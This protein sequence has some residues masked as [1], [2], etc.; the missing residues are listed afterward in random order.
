MVHDWV[1]CGGWITRYIVKAIPTS[2]C[3]DLRRAAARKTQSGSGSAVTYLGDLARGRDNHLNLMRMAAAMAVLV[4]HAYP[5]ALGPETVEPLKDVLGESLGTVAVFVFFA[6]SGFLITQSFERASGPA[7]WGVARVLRL[8]PGLLVVV[9]LTVLV[10]GPLVTRDGLAEYMQDPATGRYVVR[11]L[12]LVALQYDLPG[13]FD[14][15]P[16]PEVINGS[17]WTLRHEV[18]C[19]LAVLAAG[20]AGLLRPGLRMV[21]LLA[22]YALFYTA[23]RLLETESWMPELLVQ[24]RRLSLPFAIGVACY[25]WRDWLPLRWEFGAAVALAAGILSHTPLRSEALAVAIAYWVFL[26]GYLPKGRLLAYNR[27]GDYSYGVYIYAFPMQ[28]L[29]M[30]LFGPITPLANMALAVPATLLLAMLSWHFVE[31]PALAS[32]RRVMAA[33]ARRK[34]AATRPGAPPGPG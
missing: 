28:Q 22:A 9:L 19:Y 10:L 11:N 15:L 5:V 16:F 32:R 6:I 33:L 12:T 8:A 18:F 27:F 31:K 4:S 21:G 25:V 3:P 2:A 14:D 13:V 26:L 7:D 34:E 23:I 17:L 29:A 1:R 30:H 20:L 24:F